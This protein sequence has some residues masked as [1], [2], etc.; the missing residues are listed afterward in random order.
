MAILTVSDFPSNLDQSSLLTAI[1]IA[2]S[3]A[4]SPEGA[5]RQLEEA[6]YTEVLDFKTNIFYFTHHP[7]NQA[8]PIEIKQ[9]GTSNELWGMKY[10]TDNWQTLD[11]DS[12]QI[13][14][15][16]NELVVSNAAMGI[17][18]SQL[19]SY[20]YYPRNPLLKKHRAQIRVKYKAGFDFTQTSNPEIASI[21]S[22]LIALANQILSPSAGSGV[23]SFEIDDAGHKTEYF[24]AS[25]LNQFSSKSNSQIGL[26]LKNFHK[27]RPHSYAFH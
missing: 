6:I 14:F 21:K 17:S 13:D 3:M 11:S 2:E 26:I 19:N 27:Y 22:N 20:N 10:Q 16:L 18:G 8:Y 5:N 23:K 15:D 9:R 12:Y 1:A 25:E 24:S 7:I 4:Q